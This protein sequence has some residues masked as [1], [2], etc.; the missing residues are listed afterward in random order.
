MKKLL[1]LIALIALFA[2]LPAH[3][4]M[5]FAASNSAG[6]SDPTPNGTTLTEKCGNGSSL[7]WAGGTSQCSQLWKDG[8]GSGGVSIVDSPAG[9]GTGVGAKSLQIVKANGQA[10]YVYTVGSFPR[11]PSATAYDLYGKFYID[12]TTVSIAAG[13]AAHLLCVGSNSTMPGNEATAAGMVK[14]YNNSGTYVI[15]GKG[16]NSSG[17]TTLTTG[18][19]TFR[20]HVQSGA[21]NSYFKLDSG[22]NQTFTA[23][24]VDSFYV[25]LS[26]SIPPLTAMATRTGCLPILRTARTA[27]T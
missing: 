21:G 6:V 24:A 18:W 5:L 15:Y 26:T 12:M 1:L 16:N 13:N 8:S 10:N 9:G 25:V 17:Y 20:L 22:D 7:C 4:Q 3:G 11:I 2:P 23:N 19:H 27:P 14:L